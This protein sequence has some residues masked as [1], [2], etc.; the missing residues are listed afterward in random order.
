M[1]SFIIIDTE[2]NNTFEFFTRKEIVDFL[3]V[4]N[5]RFRRI[6]RRGYYKQYKFKHKIYFEQQDEMSELRT[7]T[8]VTQFLMLSNIKYSKEHFNI[9]NSEILK[10]FRTFAEDIQNG[11]HIKLGNIEFF[12]NLNESD[13][14]NLIDIFNFLLIQNFLTTTDIKVLKRLLTILN[15]NEYIKPKNNNS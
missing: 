11:V 1:K 14:T 9:T 2:T 13:K 5:N 10:Y 6:I 8:R 3:Q 7:N 15:T 4:K 12:N